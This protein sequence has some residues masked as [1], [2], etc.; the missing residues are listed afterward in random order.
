MSELGEFRTK[1][2]YDEVL[3]IQRLFSRCGLASMLYDLRA[4]HKKLKE[5]L[6]RE[7]EAVDFYAHDGNWTAPFN[8]DNKYH[9]CIV[10]SDVDQCTVTESFGGKKARETKSKRE[11]EL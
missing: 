4:K 2:E 8:Y 1:K 10:L 6:K 11:I 7:R 3:D 5:E 9:P